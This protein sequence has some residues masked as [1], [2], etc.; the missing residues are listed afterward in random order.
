M[1]LNILLLYFVFDWYYK[2]VSPQNGDTRGEPPP[3]PPP[4]PPSPS[5]ATGLFVVEFCCIA[6]ALI[7]QKSIMIMV[8]AI[9]EYNRPQYESD[10]YYLYFCRTRW[11][12]A[13]ALRS[14]NFGQTN[15]ADLMVT[16]NKSQRSPWLWLLWIKLK[17]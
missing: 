9:Q 4:P 6:C 14:I 5:E 15:K 3:P 7:S 17:S 2:M 8:I 11:Y 12:L 10:L 1:I 13:I 16:Y